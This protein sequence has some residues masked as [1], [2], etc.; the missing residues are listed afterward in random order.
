MTCTPNFYGGFVEHFF[1]HQNSSI[2]T[3]ECCQSASI[4][5]NLSRA[6]YCAAQHPEPKAVSLH[7]NNLIG[8]KETLTTKCVNFINRKRCTLHVA[9]ASGTNFDKDSFKFRYRDEKN[10]ASNV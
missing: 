2:K 5:K 1:H 4:G 10:L 7:P 9:I 8:T 6:T 3:Q